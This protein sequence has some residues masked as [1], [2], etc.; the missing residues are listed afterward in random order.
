MKT[1]F[2]SKWFVALGVLGVTA[3]AGYGLQLARAE[4]APPA[5]EALTY[6]GTIEQDG[7]P[8][9]GEADVLISLWNSGFATDAA[10]FD[11]MAGECEADSIQGCECAALAS[12][13]YV[14]EGRF[15]VT[16]PASCA[17][18]V[19]EYSQLWMEVRVRIGDEEE[20]F[21]RTPL[22]AAPYALEAENADHS[23]FA[24]TLSVEASRGIVPIGAIIPW[25]EPA[26]SALEIPDNFV[27]CDGTVLDDPAYSA[28]P[29]FEQT[30]PFLNH[31]HYLKG[32]AREKIG[33]TSGSHQYTF[34]TA[35][36]GTHHHKWSEFRDGPGYDTNHWGSWFGDGSWTGS[37]DAV[38]IE[39]G[40]TKHAAIAFDD[41]IHDGNLG[42]YTTVNGAHTHGV[43]FESVQNPNSEGK[44]PAGYIEPV[45]MRV[46]YLIRVL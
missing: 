30:L 46:F 6:E 45:H 16:L 18:A 33:D 22:R 32:G 17:A 1:Q 36:A 43:S 4:G 26:E 12:A 5:A 21:G 8:Y 29:L 42:F 37:I 39:V 23:D 28:S 31:E 38:G 15:S 44:P 2:R 3:S 14:T 20:D 19:H 40:S 34:S 41:G 25:W 11:T 35:S 9:D 27:P 24:E 7:A 13:A 10:D